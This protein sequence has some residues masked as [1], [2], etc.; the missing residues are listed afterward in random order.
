[1]ISIETSSRIAKESAIYM[2]ISQAKRLEALELFESGYGYKAVSTKLNVNVETVREWAYAWRAL[3]ADLY[4]HPEKCSRS[5]SVETQLAA[6]QDRKNGVPI[7]EVMKRYK[8]ANR[9]R[10]KEWC[11]QYALYGPEVFTRNSYQND[12]KNNTQ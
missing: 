11:N 8:I 2:R 3:G 12:S 10:I 1:M 6:V 5:Y 4:K 9:H 7:V